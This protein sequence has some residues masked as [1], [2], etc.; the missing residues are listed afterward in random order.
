[1]TDPLI[2]KFLEDDNMCSLLGGRLL[3]I[4]VEESVYEYHV[5]E[6]HFNPN[7]ILH[8]GA[9]YSVMD[10]SQGAFIHYLLREKFSH[11]PYRQAA[12]G[13]ATIR[14]LAPLKVGR[15]TIRTTFRSKERRKYFIHSIASDESG[16]NVA[17]LD[18]IWVA[19]P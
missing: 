17:E 9:L 19:L 3:K 11:E 10:S 6:A 8:G 14:Y 12:S 16:R 18:E 15:I 5:Q 2:K 4:T 7:Q 1:M 13:T